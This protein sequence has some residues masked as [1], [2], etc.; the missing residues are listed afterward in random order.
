MSGYLIIDSTEIE[1][2]GRKKV[3]IRSRV[4]E[5][6]GGMMYDLGLYIFLSSFTNLPLV[7]DYLNV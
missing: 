7:K 3:S 1:M 6:K 2:K 5:G 4:R